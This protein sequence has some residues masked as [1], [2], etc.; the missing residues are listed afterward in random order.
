MNIQ[1]TKQQTQTL[2]YFRKHAQGWANSAKGTSKNDVNV[3]QQRNDYVLTVIKQRKETHFLLDVGCGTG[4]LVCAAA[5][6]GIFAIGVDFAQEMVQIAQDNAQ[7]NNIELA[8]FECGSIFDYN[9]QPAHYDLISANGFIEYISV[10]QFQQFLT[11]VVHSLKPGGSL[12]LGSRNKLFNLFSLND[13]TATEIA[14]GTVRDLLFEAMA[15][16]N[17]RYLDEL[18]SLKPAALPEHMESQMPTGI[19]VSIRYQFTPMQLIQLLQKKGLRAVHL[20]PIHIHAVVPKLKNKYPSLHYDLS[21]L[22][23]SFAM[24]NMELIPFSS[25]FMLH[26]VKD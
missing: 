8:Q 6:Q 3:I 22:L 1:Y 10:E 4:D 26:A 14:E 19:D 23:Q 9:L 18:S 11:L 25:S 15:I 5:Q 2:N 21:N 24:D 13:F 17:C 16:V 12:V 7:K 20:F